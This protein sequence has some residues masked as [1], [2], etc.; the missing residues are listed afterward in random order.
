MSMSRIMGL[1]LTAL[2]VQT[3]FSVFGPLLGPA[4]YP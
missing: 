3:F 1:V 2:A 4:V